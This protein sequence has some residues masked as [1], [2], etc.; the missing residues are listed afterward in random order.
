MSNFAIIRVATKVDNGNTRYVIDCVSDGCNYSATINRP[1]ADD[2]VTSEEMVT[3][4]MD[5][6]RNN[7]GTFESL[8]R[9]RVRE[10]VAGALSYMRSTKNVTVQRLW[11]IE[12]NLNI[13]EVKRVVH[14]DTHGL[15]MTH[16]L[17][18]YKDECELKGSTFSHTSLFFDSEEDIDKH[19]M[20][21][22]VDSVAT[23]LVSEVARDYAEVHNIVEPMMRKCIM[24]EIENGMKISGSKK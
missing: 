16:W 3:A 14:Y 23:A 17:V 19:I 10:A 20:E 8:P 1:R 2:E 24:S 9:G 22:M 15:F 5:I 13:N 6:L 21:K 4:I 18:T 7:S 11:I 12:S